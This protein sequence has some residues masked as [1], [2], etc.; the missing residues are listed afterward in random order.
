MAVLSGGNLLLNADGGPGGVGA[1]LSVPPASLG[2]DGVLDPGESF[3]VD[4][5]IGLQL[6][7]GFTFFVNAFG[8]PMGNNFNPPTFSSAGYRV[9]VSN[10]D[11]G[12]A[13][14]FLP[15]LSR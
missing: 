12:V 3:D 5:E 4:F 15:M 9:E 14:M 8:T 10:A 2:S 13:E 1:I 6:R 11:L 7:R